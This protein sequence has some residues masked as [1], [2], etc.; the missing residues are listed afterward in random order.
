MLPPAPHSHTRFGSDDARRSVR[1]AHSPSPSHSHS[2]GHGL[3]S[4]SDSRPYGAYP[5]V[6]EI[7]VVD[8]TGDDVVVQTAPAHGPGAPGALGSGKL[9][10]PGF[11]HS[12]GPSEERL[13]TPVG[14]PPPSPPASVDRLVLVDSPQALSPSSES[15]PLELPSWD[16]T[17]E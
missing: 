17:N 2:H 8:V 7:H 12:R 14:P 13:A 5:H 10:V 3:R 15:H 1:S 11:T 9:A 16:H 6:Q 4:S